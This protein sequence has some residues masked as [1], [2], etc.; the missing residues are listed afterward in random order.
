MKAFFVIN[1]LAGGGAERVFTTLLAHSRETCRDMECTVVLLDNE[2]HEAYA[3]PEWITVKRLD[4]GG[5]LVKSIRRLRQLIAAERPDITL[6]FLTRANVAAVIA[7]R[8]HNL[9]VV[10]SERVN[11]SAHL[12]SG[13]RSSLVKAL[14]RRFYRKADHVIATS[15]GV[16]EDLSSHFAVDARKISVIANPVD[17]ASIREL[18][19]A[20]DPVGADERD[21]ATMGRLVEN[22]NAGLAIRA[23]A[24]SALPG[25]LI[26][27]GTGPLEADLR[28]LAADL[29]CADRIVFAGFQQNP[30]ATIARVRG[31]VLPSNAEGF[32]NAM[33]E[34]MALGV[35]VVATDC[36]SGPSEILATELSG[37]A[38]AEGLGGIL[39]PMNSPA[40]MVE[41]MQLA[42]TPEKRQTLSEKATRRIDEFSI[43]RAV[44]SF[45]DVLFGALARRSEA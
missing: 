15:R 41:A 9:P 19:T 36:P 8:R 42:S 2:E 11:T 26:V 21:W 23:F 25:R 7:C 1:S 16:A 20:P 18:G 44:D 38:P 33:C 13:L 35:P 39:V 6:S 22:K 40:A 3:L 28:Q 30:Y 5:G 12:P 43:A 17:A 37:E 29:G 24:Q 34:A 4:C 32:P 31:Y 10:I 45:W 14:V 27:L